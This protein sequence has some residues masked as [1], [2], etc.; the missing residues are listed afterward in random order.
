MIASPSFKITLPLLYVIPVLVPS[1]WELIIA[2]GKLKHLDFYVTY[3]LL[4]HFLL[5][6]YRAFFQDPSTVDKSLHKFQSEV[7]AYHQSWENRYRRLSDQVDD[8]TEK[9]QLEVI[10]KENEIQERETAEAVVQS[11]K[12]ELQAQESWWHW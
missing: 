9:L 4:N 1:S 3:Q 7:Q 2:H 10:A 11:L 12:D 5:G 8:L 6:Y